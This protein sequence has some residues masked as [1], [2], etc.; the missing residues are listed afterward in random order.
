MAGLPASFLGEIGESPQLL[1]YTGRP[2]VLNSQ[3]E[4]SVIRARY[5][6]YLEALYAR[7]EQVLWDFAAKYQADY[8][9]ISRHFAT[10][11]ET[12]SYV[13]LAGVTG[14]L[15]LDMNVVR[16]HFQP[17]G[18]Q[19]F[20]PVYDNEL[21]RVL[22]VL[23]NGDRKEAAPWRRGFN[24]WWEADNFTVT[25]GR[26]VDPAGDGTR[27][28]NFE[29]AL[30]ALQDEQVR[31]L[32]GVEAR[33]RQ[34]QPQGQTRPE[35]MMLHRQY[36]QTRLEGLTRGNPAA[37]DLQGRLA[38]AIRARLSEIDPASGRSLATALTELAHGPEGWLARLRAHAGE[39][40]H[41]A[42]CGQLLALAGRYREAAELF[43][44]AAAFYGRSGDGCGSRRPT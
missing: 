30:S 42:A 1:L 33:W 35:L 24:L 37:A 20:A 18:L 6:E 3:F 14:G 39:P 43:G 7:D 5:R 36:V 9:F 40:S 28:R 11:D 17:E 38:N 25:D 26:L 2:V 21:Y 13:Y 44:E 22:K 41:Y 31:M 32:A 34:S 29:A 23:P 10:R 27:I 15:T 12:G 16:M 4:N 8:I 19:L